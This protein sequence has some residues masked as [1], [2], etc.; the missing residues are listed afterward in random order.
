MSDMAPT[1]TRVRDTNEFITAVSVKE[2][3]AACLAVF[4][5]RAIPAG[6]FGRGGTRTPDGGMDYEGKK[7]APG[8]IQSLGAGDEIQVVDPKGSG[9][10]A[11]GFLK[12]QQGLIAAG[13]GLS[14]EAV[15]R[16][17]SGATYSSAR[18]NAIEDEN[19]YTEDVELLT[20]FMSEVYETFVISCY[21]SGLVDMPGFWDKKPPR[22]GS[23]R[24]RKAPPEKPPCNPGKRRF[25][26]FARNRARTGKRP[27]MKWP[28]SWNMAD[29]SASS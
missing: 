18:Q 29:P 6:G 7:L 11:A 4:I 17:M 22:S 1:I 3:I 20:D 9:S 19:T 23:T 26:T 25:R 13:Q 14:Y 5:K 2:R 15:S 8:M 10:D 21:L 27:S 28:R 16:D 12:T 24:Q